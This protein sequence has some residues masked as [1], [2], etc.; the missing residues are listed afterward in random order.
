[1]ANEAMA[2]GETVRR[3]VLGDAHVDRSQA[4]AT[5]FT[6]D[7]QALATEYCWGA[8]WTREGLDLKTRSLINIAMLAA[9]GRMGEFKMHVGGATRNGVTE[10]EIKEV[11]LQVAIYC[12][13][14]A[15]ND[16]FATASA[17]LKD[18]K[19]AADG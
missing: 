17:V 15:G 5:E 3:R 1:M 13:I 7:F 9:L 16:A 10:D 18:L 19:D 11:L 6:R 4:N 14:P 8:I 2:R 12:G